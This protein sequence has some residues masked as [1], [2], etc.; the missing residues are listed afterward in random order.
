[1]K[2]LNFINLSKNIIK[3]I[4]QELA[5]LTKNFSGAEIEGLVRAAQSTAMNR[6]IKAASKVE[7]DPQAM[8]KLYV[9]RGDFLHAL[10]HDIKPVMIIICY[11]MSLHTPTHMI[12]KVLKIIVR[13]SAQQQKHSN[14]SY[15][16]ESSTGAHQFLLCS[17][18]VNCT[19]NKLVLQN[20][21][22]YFKLLQLYFA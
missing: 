7:L 22:V 18:T 13:L 5:T 9:N 1:M 3:Y 11:T 19:S 21:A 20:Q 10:E 2:K 8:E 17:K 12:C 16:G 6:L 4:L 15:Q 14:T